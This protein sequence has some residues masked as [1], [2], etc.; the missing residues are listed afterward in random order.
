MLKKGRI[1]K[2]RI[3]LYEEGN[4]KVILKIWMME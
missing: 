4:K 3:E 1:Y 2:N